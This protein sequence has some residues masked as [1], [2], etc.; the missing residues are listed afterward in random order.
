MSI[1]P[2]NLGKRLEGLFGRG[3]TDVLPEVEKLIGETVILV[4]AHMPTIDTTRAKARLG[5]EHQPW[6]L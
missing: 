2:D 1:K 6:Q 3:M 4:E 5:W